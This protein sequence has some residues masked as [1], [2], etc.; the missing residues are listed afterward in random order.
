MKMREISFSII[1]MSK[2]E[3]NLKV[4]KRKEDETMRKITLFMWIYIFIFDSYLRAR[5]YLRV[6]PPG[7]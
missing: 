6:T 4:I 1:I 7:S 2:Y 3:I 5:T